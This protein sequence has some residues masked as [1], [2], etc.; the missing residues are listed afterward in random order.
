[1]DGDI[2][3]LQGDCRQL[4]DL[5]EGVN[6]VLTDPPY[7][8][9]SGGKPDPLNT[10]HKVMAGRWM[11]D[12]N[13]KGNLF[14]TPKIEFSEW[15]PLVVGCMAENA[16]FYAM[17]NSKNMLKLLQAMEK[18]EVRLHTILAWNKVTAT[19]NRWYMQNMEFVVYGW[20]GIAR[21]IN[22]CRAKQLVKAPQVDETGHPTEKPVALME[23]YIRNSTDPGALVLDPFMG[24]GTTGVA[25]VR[26]GRRF[27]GI[28]SNP[29]FFATAQQR[30]AAEQTK[31][32]NN[33]RFG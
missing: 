21:P 18:A 32:A 15:I 23:Y 11:K 25:C 3:L 27:I 2:Q 22:D 29:D 24:S 19:A 30:I 31:G 17:V 10:K 13:N 12:Y 5:V 1:M 6:L 20:R 26:S 8:L 9:T 28:E 7:S 14:D 4:L 16:D 33:G